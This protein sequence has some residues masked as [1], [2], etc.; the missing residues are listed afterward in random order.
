[1]T[2][3]T[4]VL[5][6]PDYRPY[7]DH[8]FVGL[9]DKMGSD[10]KIE[11]DARQSYGKGTRSLT[12]TR[13]LIRYLLRHRHTSPFEMGEVKFHIKV[14]I[15]VMRQVVRHRTAS[16]N[17]WSG[18]Y[19]EMTDEFYVPRPERLQTQSETNKQGSGL[20]LELDDK[21]DLLQWFES[22]Y[23]DSYAVYQKMLELGLARELARVVLPV[24]NYTELSWKCDINNFM[25]MLSL[26]MDPHAQW[27]IVE[28]ANIMYELAK[29]H[30]PLTFEAFEDYILNGKTFSAYDMQI[31]KHLLVNYIPDVNGPLIEDAIGEAAKDLG[32]LDKMSKR[33]IEELKLK[34]S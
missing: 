8:G 22:A 20:E 15:F 4:E 30:F 13:T 14:P 24:G 27:E 33:E 3:K 26:R 17:E 10:A 6:N 28:M 31:I 34:L 23:A 11:T 16:L 21:V 9:V 12:D 29:P 7:L 2:N 18:R 25:K 1:M 5:D 19:S 32:L